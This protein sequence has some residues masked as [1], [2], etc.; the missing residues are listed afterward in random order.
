MYSQSESSSNKSRKLLKSAFRFI[1]SKVVKTN[2]IYDWMQVHR[3]SNYEREEFPKSVNVRRSPEKCCGIAFGAAADWKNDQ[4]WNY[5][6][7]TEK[8]NVNMASSSFK[9]RFVLFIRTLFYLCYIIHDSTLKNDPNLAPIPKRGGIPY[10][11]FFW[12]YILDRVFKSWVPFRRGEYVSY[13][14]R[15]IFSA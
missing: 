5:L 15:L 13:G 1:C 14:R 10:C 9:I 2:S 6:W 4:S 12:K 7:V 11:Q 8:R 3:G